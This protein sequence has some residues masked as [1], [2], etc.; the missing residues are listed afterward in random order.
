MRSWEYASNPH[1]CLKKFLKGQAKKMQ[2]SLKTCKDLSFF[3]N[4]TENVVFEALQNAPRVRQV[5]VT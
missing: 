1:R 3:S 2:T 4:I 5:T